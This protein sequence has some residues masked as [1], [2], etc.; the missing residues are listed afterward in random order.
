MFEFRLHAYTPDSQFQSQYHSTHVS[1]NFIKDDGYEHGLSDIDL[2]LSLFWVLI[3]QSIT[4]F[5]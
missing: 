4:N 1:H 5:H 3:H 2:I